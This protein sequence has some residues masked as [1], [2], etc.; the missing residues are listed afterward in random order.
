[1]TAT[2]R[3]T[4]TY[5]SAASDTSFAFTLP[6]GWQAG[7]VVYIAVECRGTGATTGTPTGWT[8]VAATF[9]AV[10]V[11]NTCLTV[12]RRVM[13]AGDTD[14]VTITGASARFSVAALALQA[15]DGTT[16]EDGVAASE[17]AQSA[18][19]NSPVAN[20][21]TPTGADDL[22]LCFFGAGDT[23]TTNLAT[24]YTAPS[25]MTLVVQT[26][27]AQSGATDSSVC[28]CSLV[29]SSNSATGT[30]TATVIPSLGTTAENS[31]AVT[32]VVKSAAAAAAAP[33]VT[34][35]PVAPGWHPGQGLPGLPGGTPFWSPPSAGAPATVTITATATLA[36]AGAVTATVTQ[37]VIASPAAAGTVAAVVT[38]AATATLAGA[39]AVTDVVT[40]AVT[41]SLA[42]AGAVNATGTAPGGGTPATIAG[43][44]AVTAVVTQGVTAAPAGAGAVTAAAVQAAKATAAGAGAVAAV[45]TEAVTAAAAGA[46]T[47]TARATEAP[48]A[49]LAG[50][51]AVSAA[52]QITGTANLAGAG[53]VTPRPALVAGSTLAAAGAVTAAA[54]L[55]APAV[56]AA[57]GTVAAVSS[58]TIAF[59]PGALSASDSPAAVLTASG[60]TSA[61]TA[62]AAPSGT[63]TAATQ[64][65]GGP[66]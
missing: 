7:D 42:G 22:L 32:L 13:Q 54:G 9:N 59:T 65:T 1:M 30:K 4:S 48:V 6:P 58:S 24:T 40:E 5:A 31:Q 44:G 47:V 33:G 45:V 20:S 46:G 18:A 26:S 3:S 12:L 15:A 50:A 60:T 53:A 35:M 55:R 10:G 11:T 39:G 51:G 63:L 21:V 52:G 16:P 8:A 37:A 57:A 66:G 2:V 49:T 36:G 41:A 28:A 43:A 23:I 64:R 27:T 56:L 38:Q 19:T 62:A 29:L 61:L 25:G 34:Q 14:P 17:A